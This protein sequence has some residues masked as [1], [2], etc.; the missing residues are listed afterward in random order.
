MH[1]FDPTQDDFVA[2][3]FET[4]NN[5]PSSACAIGL[6]RFRR[7][8]V[9]A[10]LKSL[11]RPR[12]RFFLYT[13]V[14]GIRSRD[15]ATAPTFAQLWPRCVAFLDGAQVFV[16]HNMSFDR[17]VLEACCAQAGLQAPLGQYLCTLG[18]AR[19]TL[20]SPAGLAVV[21]EKLAIPLD[22]HEPLS[23][24]RACGHVMLAL[25]GRMCKQ[26]QGASS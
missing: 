16:A 8:E 13:D 10:E 7:G 6:V 15:V 22:H 21:C 19:R 1:A 24:A 9:V 20:G 14:H 11:I 2:L 12:D 3:D 17:R 23:D 5:A 18:L 26:E 25:H 4:A